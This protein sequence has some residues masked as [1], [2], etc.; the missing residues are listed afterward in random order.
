MRNGQKKPFTIWLL[1]LCV[2]LLSAGGFYG[3]ISF[4]LDPTGT[5]IGMQGETLEKLPVRNFF[6]PGLFLIAAYGIFPLIVAA[7]LFV[8][9]RS[10][11]VRRI[12]GRHWVWTFSYLLGVV[13]VFWVLFQML[14][15]G[16]M[17]PIQFITLVLGLLIFIFS[18]TKS[19]KKYFSE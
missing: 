18:M 17:H 19:I 4:I 7:G 6:L 5:M 8:N 3:G 10:Q 2:V 12:S 14:F 9:S 16:F 11:S 13:L 15:I 1:L